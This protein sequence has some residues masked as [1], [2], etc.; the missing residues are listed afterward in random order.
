[1]RGT[2][3]GEGDLFAITTFVTGST[4]GMVVRGKG[5]PQVCILIGVKCKGGAQNLCSGC[6][7]NRALVF[8]GFINVMGRTIAFS[9]CIVGFSNHGSMAQTACDSQCGRRE[10]NEQYKRKCESD[11]LFHEYLP[12]HM[13]SGMS[14]SDIPTAHIVHWNHLNL[15]CT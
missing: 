4:V 10:H 1:M 12:I 2:L 6:I 8:Y 7:A 9:V 14:S 13:S 3:A 5:V 15:F 11:H